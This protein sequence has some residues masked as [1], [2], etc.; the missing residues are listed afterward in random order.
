MSEV[1]H[2]VTVLIVYVAGINIKNQF[3]ISLL[4]VEATSQQQLFNFVTKGPIT[5]RISARAEISARLTGLKFCCDYM[6]N[7]SPG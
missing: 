6:M 1:S 4:P 2:L 3:P 5:W 7:F